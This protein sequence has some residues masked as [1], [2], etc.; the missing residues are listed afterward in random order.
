MDYCKKTNGANSVMSL[1]FCLF[2]AILGIHHVHIKMCAQF[3]NDLFVF[4]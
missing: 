4:I 3:V 1:Q 2:R